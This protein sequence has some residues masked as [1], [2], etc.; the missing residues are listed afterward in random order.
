MPSLDIFCLRIFIAFSRLSRTSTSTGFPNVF[1]MRD[2]VGTRSSGPGQRPTDSRLGVVLVRQGDGEAVEHGIRALRHGLVDDLVLRVAA[3]PVGDQ[4]TEQLELLGLGR[5]E[6][7]HTGYVDH[8]ASPL[9]LS[10][11]LHACHNTLLRYG[12]ITAEK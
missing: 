2:T 1:S 10:C 6:L 12:E 3:N 7:L 9:V 11:H 4:L 5:R 8:A